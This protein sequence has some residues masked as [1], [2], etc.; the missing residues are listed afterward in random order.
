GAGTNALMLEEYDGTSWQPISSPACD[1]L[2]RT[3]GIGLSLG[4]DPR[5]RRLVGFDASTNEVW[6]LRWDADNELDESCIAG[7]DADGDGFAGC[8]DPDCW[9]YCT[10]SCPPGAPCDP[11]LPHC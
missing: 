10:P 4:Y 7:K 11:T 8:D 1:V 2:A 6:Q 9:G 3:V 5:G